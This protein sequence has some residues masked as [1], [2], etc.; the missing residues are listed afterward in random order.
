M[1]TLAGPDATRV[2][3]SALN[4]W[5][6]VIVS[7]LPPT[8]GWG[9]RFTLGHIIEAGLMDADAAVGEVRVREKVTPAPRAQTADR[10]PALAR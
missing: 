3:T 5:A 8:E 6:T 10:P 1:A 4:F 2:F 9:S 7:G